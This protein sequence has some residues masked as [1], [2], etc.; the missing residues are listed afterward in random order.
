MN[1][2]YTFICGEDAKYIE[3]L[4]NP[5]LL[6]VLHEMLVKCFKKMVIPK[7]VALIKYANLI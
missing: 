3:E 4:E 1:I 7:P 6:E 5:C 2:L